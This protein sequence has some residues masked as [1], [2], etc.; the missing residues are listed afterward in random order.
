V[1]VLEPED[2]TDADARRAGYADRDTLMR[3]L[4]RYPEGDLYRVEFHHAGADPRQALR[5]D[6]DLSADDW[7]RIVARLDRASRQG[8]WTLQVL[9]LVAER[10]AERAAEL[11][12]VAGRDRDS[13]K[14]DVRKLKEMG[15]TESL[16][17]GYRLS[18]RGRAV[19]DRLD[20]RDGE[21]QPNVASHSAAE[22]GVNT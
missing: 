22:R 2:V 18:P 20:R 19:L 5:E 8:P 13:F 1:A 7:D 3:D 10:P 12:E 11:A 17:T 21:R 14:R 16:G 6:A 9:A 15:L 4:D